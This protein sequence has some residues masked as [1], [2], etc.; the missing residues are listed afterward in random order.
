MDK[1]VL[2]VEDEENVI[3]LLR[4]NM[5]RRGYDVIIAQ[6]GDEAMD[7]MYRTNPQIV[8]LDIRLPGMNGWEVCKEIRKNPKTKEAYIIVISA[9][10]QKEDRLK[11][12]TCGASCFLAKPF[13]MGTLI[14]LISSAE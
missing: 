5:V 4:I 11:A 10:T 8:L 14:D 3:E 12:A 9:A 2:I 13:D 1:K 7:I 6:N